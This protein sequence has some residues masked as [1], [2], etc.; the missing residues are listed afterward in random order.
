MLVHAS[1]YTARNRLEIECSRARVTLLELTSE[2]PSV[3]VKHGL[4]RSSKNIDGSCGVDGICRPHHIEHLNTVGS[5]C[6][7]HL[8]DV[9]KIELRVQL[10]AFVVAA[11]NRASTGG[12][13][14]CWLL[15]LLV[16]ASGISREKMWFF[17]LDRLECGCLLVWLGCLHGCLP[18]IHCQL[19]PIWCWL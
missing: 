4:A 19:W 2:L 8:F 3:L 17:R 5:P 11:S 1:V 15:G 16:L 6:F 13:S 14:S 7:L 18:V 10:V 12:S 9:F